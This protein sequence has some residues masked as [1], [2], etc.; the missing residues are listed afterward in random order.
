MK[1]MI[2]L[3]LYASIENRYRHLHAIRT[4]AGMNAI[5][6]QIEQQVLAHHMPVDFYAGFQRF[7]N[8]P[9]QRPVYH[10]LGSVCHHVSIFG[11][12]DAPLPALVGVEFVE[13]LPE[14][15]LV[16]EWFLLVDTP[17]FWT[18]LSTREIPG[19]DPNSGERR[20]DGLWTFDAPV[21][22]SASQLLMEAL[23]QTYTPIRQRYP[24]LQ[25]QNVSELMQRLSPDLERD[26]QRCEAA[27][28]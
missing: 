18:L 27:Q 16:Q 6:H 10:Q 11:L 3:S 8:F 15:P 7:S 21:V 23:G 24:A 1:D 26:L 25:D 9:H 14:M 20:F 12:A 22:E 17:E 13:L 28:N 19:T 5:S 4:R 2:S